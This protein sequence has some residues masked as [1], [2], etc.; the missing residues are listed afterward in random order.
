MDEMLD[1]SP[2]PPDG[3]IRQIL[4]KGIPEEGRQILLEHEVTGLTA[5]RRPLEADGKPVD[6]PCDR[7]FRHRSRAN[8]S[9]WA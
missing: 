5:S 6:N 8:L 3:E 4:L 2:A 7:R 9:G 1:T